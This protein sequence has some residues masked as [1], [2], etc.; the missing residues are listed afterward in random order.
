M[1]LC[2]TSSSSC[3]SSQSLPNETS[4]KEPKLRM[5]EFRTMP[6][7]NSLPSRNGTNEFD[8]VYNIEILARRDSMSSYFPSSPHFP[9]LTIAQTRAISATVPSTTLLVACIP[10]QEM[11]TTMS[12]T[13]ISPWCGPSILVGI[14]S[15]PRCSPGLTSVNSSDSSATK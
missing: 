11:S 4:P 14:P 5:R 9:C 15:Y 2:A 1:H 10:P 3:G 12:T 7:R 13:F 6:A 8:S